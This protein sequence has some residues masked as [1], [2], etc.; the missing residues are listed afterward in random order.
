MR[1]RMW[2]IWLMLG[3]RSQTRRRA[4]PR[5]SR[6]TIAHVD[7]HGGYTTGITSTGASII[8][9]TSFRLSTFS[10]SPT[11]NGG[12][13]VLFAIFF[14]VVFVGFVTIDDHIVATTTLHAHAIYGHALGQGLGQGRNQLLPHSNVFTNPDFN[15]LVC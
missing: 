8:Q 10:R 14:V 13:V 12:R 4:H 7:I 11:A 15:A 9:S 3:D 2:V 6:C 1:V 5:R